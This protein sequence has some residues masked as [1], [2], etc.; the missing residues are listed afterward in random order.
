LGAKL[1]QTFPESTVE[2]IPGGRGDFI[3][4]VDQRVVWD[5]K[6]M[7]NNFPDEDRLVNGLRSA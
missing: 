1:E 3:V 4:T 6:Q 7:N 5:K 2:L